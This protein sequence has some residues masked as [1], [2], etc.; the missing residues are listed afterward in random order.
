MA[1]VVDD[2][3]VQILYDLG[4]FHVHL[5]KRIEFLLELADFE[6]LAQDDFLGIGAAL[7]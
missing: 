3:H 4:E 2:F 5:G 7:F 1:P 6:T